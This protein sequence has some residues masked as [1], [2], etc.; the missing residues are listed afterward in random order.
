LKNNLPE[1]I[2]ALWKVKKHT[3]NKRWVR[4][5]V[6]GKD[7]LYRYFNIGDYHTNKKNENIRRGFC[8]NKHFTRSPL[9][10]MRG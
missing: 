9:F 7:Y 3:I 4:G 8:L 10:A 2:L 1:P 6:Y 5:I